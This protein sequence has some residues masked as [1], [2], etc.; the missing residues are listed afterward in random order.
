VSRLRRLVKTRRALPTRAFETLRTAI[1]ESP[2]VGRST[3]AGPFQSS[4]GF[5][6]TFHGA[7]GRAKVEERFPELTPWLVATLG[8]PATR[9]MTPF[10]RRTLE[11]VPNAWYLNVLLVSEGGA[12]A[13]HLDVTLREPASVETCAPE[14]VSVLYLSVP[15][16]ID[17]GALQ[18][19]EGPT[20]VAMVTP[21]QNSAVHFRGD[22]AHAVQAF[23][24][25][26][27]GLRASVVIEQYFFDENVLARLPEFQLDSRAGFKAFLKVHEGRKTAL[28]LET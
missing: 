26:P 6:V 22:L 17:G 23:N 11:R 27:E 2:L 21:A 20:P 25:A 7:A 15:S 18:L 13:R 3:L 5:A 24:G 28:E 16:R 1:L 12:V 10:W 4:R 9:A 8:A 14:M 19:W